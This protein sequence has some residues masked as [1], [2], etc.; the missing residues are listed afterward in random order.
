MK[1]A[2]EY[3]SEIR[4]RLSDLDYLSFKLKSAGV[5]QELIDKAL[6]V[7]IDLLQADLDKFLKLESEIMKIQGKVRK[8][9]IEDLSEESKTLMR[10]FE[11]EETLYASW[12]Q[13]L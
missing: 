11:L 3:E 6:K 5:G 10:S 4:K 8:L 12:L 13:L 9:M 1:K 2:S 7:E